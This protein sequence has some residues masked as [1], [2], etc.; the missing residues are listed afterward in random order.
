[1]PVGSGPRRARGEIERLPSGSLRV[2][3]YVDVDPV[4]RKRRYLA[5]TV[6]DGPEAEQ[7]AERVR[8]RL[9]REVEERRVP[10]A[11]T[12][13]PP[14]TSKMDHE[15]RRSQLT[16][17]AIA[18]LAGVSPPTVSKVLN[19]R[20]GVAAETRRRVERLLREQGY[21][22]PEKVAR[23][24]CV[25]VVF[26]G[27]QGHLA[28]EIMRGVKQVTVG[29]GLAV[30]FTDVRGEESTG[31]RWA[32][33]LLTRRPTGVILVHMGFTPEQHGLLS[34]SGIPLVVLDP[35]SEPLYP[36]PSVS[37]AN[38]HGGIAAAQ[39]LL[40]IGH[41]RI[42]VITGPLER[43]CAKARLDGVRTA[44]EAAGVPLDK[45]L[46]RAGMWFSFE[47]GFSHARDLLRLGDPPTAVLC[48]NDL[49]AF[50]VYEAARLAGARIPDDLAV[51]GFD[52]VSYARWCGPPMTTVRQPAAE[53][54]ATAARLV[55]ALAAGGTLIQTHVELATTL[56]V[57]AST[58]APRVRNDP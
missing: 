12:P 54:G 6:P 11:G 17:A 7:A 25:E 14:K 22:R 27:M 52:D 32:Q 55:L 34:A 15:R 31:R 5:E 29:N 45:R 38:R 50:G 53:M 42:A 8:A 21:R 9:L 36:V 26:Y 47:D 33:D 4:S 24:A 39:H 40:D 56:V 43:L 57:R 49:Q 35:T 51:V 44:M 48:G 20:A 37:A 46:V 23:A 19:G 10:R 13:G 18:Q 16:V 41:R 1:M 30:G 2:R 58:A 3:V 28:V